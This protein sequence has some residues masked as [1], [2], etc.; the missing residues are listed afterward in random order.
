M[1]IAK[2]SL[3][4]PDH[5]LWYG[6]FAVSVSMFVFAY[7]TR[8]GQVSILAYYALWLPLVLVDYRKSLGNYARFGWIIPFA[9][10]ACLSVFWSAAPGVTARAAVQFASHVVCALI[11]ARTVNVRTLTLGALFGTCLILFYSLVFGQYN[12]DP[13]DGT[14]SF[15]GAFASKNQL[16]LFSSLGAYFAF[17]AIIILGE[18]GGWRLLALGCG[19]LS[20]VMLVESQSATSILALAAVLAMQVCL[21]LALL[22]SPRVR[23]A[24]VLI[25]V[26]LAIG[27]AFVGLNLG[28]L[29]LVLAAF[30]KDSTLT[31]R[32]YLWS[33][34]WAAAGQAPLF[35]VGYQAY[36]VQGFSE[37]ERLWEE[38]YIGSRSGFHFHNTFIEVLVELGAV[39]LV[40]IVVVLLRVFA[41]HLGRVIG[42][43]RNEASFV[44]FGIAAML[45]VRAFVEVDVINPYVVGSFL[46]Y[47]AA[48]Q[49]AAPR[50]AEAHFM[51]AM[52]EAPHIG[53]AA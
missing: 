38:F 7:S 21:R 50:R 3:V 28:G 18:R 13:L 11:A 42:D 24:G 12:Y 44:L 41:G 25:G 5:N 4:N 52:P 9:A 20:A 53:R 29:D 37:A 22:F 48:G 6:L 8:F 45:L 40:F 39:G 47:Y 46:L 30:G 14:Y 49:L 10:F 19:G 31:G 43:P 51:A 36:W 23:K 15:V 33:Q 35:G 17:A 27:V 2:A 34:G 1:K 32:T 16:G 26:V